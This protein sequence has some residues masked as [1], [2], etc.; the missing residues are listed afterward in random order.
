MKDVKW[1]PIKCGCG[2]GEQDVY[3]RC[4]GPILCILASSHMLK[5]CTWLFSP[6]FTLVSSIFLPRQF[7]QQP[8]STGCL[9]LVKGTRDQ[10]KIDTQVVVVHQL[11]LRRQGQAS[12]HF[13]ASMFC[14][15]DSVGL[16]NTGPSRVRELCSF[17]KPDSPNKHVNPL[18][19]RV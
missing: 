3:L 7:V 12:K 5:L 18:W 9:W 2:S 4:P 11:L 16:Y 15:S 6:A 17:E 14:E 19:L 13:V 1:L 10:A 8:H